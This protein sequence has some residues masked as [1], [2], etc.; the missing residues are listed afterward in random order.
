M[1]AADLV[2]LRQVTTGMPTPRH[3]VEEQWKAGR[4]V[5]LLYAILIPFTLF[6]LV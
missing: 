2:A 4:V 3:L 1:S 6:D 5:G